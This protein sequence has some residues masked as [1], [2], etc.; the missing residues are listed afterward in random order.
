MLVKLAFFC[1][2]RMM[3]LM[4]LSFPQ[5][6]MRLLSMLQ[7]AFET[8]KFSIGLISNTKILIL[9][10]E[11]SSCKYGTQ[12]G[13]R[14]T[15]LSG[16]FFSLYA[17]VLLFRYRTITSAYYRSAQGILLVCGFDACTCLFFSSS[18]FWCS[19]ST[20][21]TMLPT[22]SHLTVCFFLLCLSFQSKQLNLLFANQMLRTGFGILTSTPTL[23]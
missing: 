4:T 11:K 2:L 9:K 23:L 22:R 10:E 7:K 14:S 5:S 16:F 3:C 17:K 1:D 6:G 15:L 12:Q 20:S 18:F 13:R 8:H 19:F 21:V